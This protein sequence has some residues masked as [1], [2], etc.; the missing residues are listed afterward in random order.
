VS[1]ASFGPKDWM[2]NTKYNEKGKTGTVPQP[3]QSARKEKSREKEAR[4]WWARL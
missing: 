1:S 2:A 4:R 3:D